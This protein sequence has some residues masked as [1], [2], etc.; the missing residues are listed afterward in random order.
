MPPY[1]QTP[2]R[3]NLDKTGNGLPKTFKQGDPIT[4]Y[5]IGIN[6]NTNEAFAKPYEKEWKAPTKAQ[7]SAFIVNSKNETVASASSFKD[8]A[9][10]RNTFVSD[11]TSTMK[12]R[13]QTAEVY[14]AGI[15]GGVNNSLV[16][17]ASKK[18]PVKPA[19]T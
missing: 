3:G 8:I 12:S 9:K 1:T 13:N 15:G 19:S 11:S 2:G 16:R 5:G 6:P 17:V 7:P 14:N 4:N 10:L 18:K